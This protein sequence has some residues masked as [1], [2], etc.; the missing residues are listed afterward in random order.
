M[1]AWEEREASNM[2][3]EADGVG[4]PVLS[5]NGSCLYWSCLRKDD[6]LGRLSRRLLGGSGAVRGCALGSAGMTPM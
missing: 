6:L 2:D 4:G 5:V 3:V 1:A